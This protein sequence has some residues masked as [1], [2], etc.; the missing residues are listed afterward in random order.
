MGLL[1]A[2]P[3]FH[4][5]AAGSLQDEATFWAAYFNHQHQLL[6]DIAVRDVLQ[7]FA[8]FAV[9]VLVLAILNRVGPR[10]ALAQLVVLF[11]AIGAVLGAL[12]ALTYLAS[13][14]YWRSGEWSGSP[15]ARMVA[16]GRDS[17]AVGAFSQILLEAAFVSIAVGLG[18][19]ARLCDGADLPRRLAPLAYVEAGVLVLLVIA[20][21]TG[22]NTVYDVLGLISAVLVPAILAWLATTFT[23][24]APSTKSPAT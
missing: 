18:L 3:T 15:A 17:E 2:A 7:P 23:P 19:L 14:E 21:E 20:S 6:W 24:A 5:T 22:L 10:N 8:Y 16:V 12:D 9:V 13:A 1:G 4:S 11:F